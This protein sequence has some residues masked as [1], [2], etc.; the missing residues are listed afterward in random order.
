M[1]GFVGILHLE[2]QPVELPVLARM[3]RVLEHRGPDD[4]GSFVDGQV[5]FFHRRLSIIDL[6][7]GRQPMHC[8]GVT[9]AFNGEIYNYVEL[10][11]ELVRR[12]HSFRT[13]S[14]TEVLLRMYL[15]YGPEFVKSLNGMFAF[16]L[17]D[18]RRRQ[19]MA[20]R[21]HFGIKPL[22]FHTDPSRLLFAS[23]I[24]ALLQHDTVRPEVD[25]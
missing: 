5:G 6:R 9:V 17:Y 22:Y 21:D 3:A 23:E 12:G 8:D 18:S 4:K 19:L 20:A 24:K 7:S 10:R 15:E 13:S 14:D 16:L 2:P 25:Y 11:K 1:C